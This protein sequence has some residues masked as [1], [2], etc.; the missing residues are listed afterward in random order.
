MQP[1]QIMH[2]SVENC[3]DKGETQERDKGEGQQESIKK[4]EVRRQTD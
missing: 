2:V 1:N 4:R 3:E